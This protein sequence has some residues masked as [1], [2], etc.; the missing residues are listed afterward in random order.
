[1]KDFKIEE[2]KTFVKDIVKN[3]HADGVVIGLSGGKDSAC[4]AA[5]CV[6]AGVKVYGV[7]L[8]IFSSK[9]DDQYVRLL[10]ERFPE[11]EMIEWNTRPGI[12]YSVL[13]E[14]FLLLSDHFVPPKTNMSAAESM[15]RSNIKPRLRMIALYALAQAR[16]CLVVGTGNASEAYVGYFTKWGDGA[17]DFNP[18]ADLLKDEVVELGLLLGV[19]EK[20]MRRQPSAGLW[21]GQTDE[22]EMGFTYADI[23]KVMKDET[24]SISP[25]TA[26]A[27]MTKHF[28]S[29]HKLNPIPTFLDSPTGRGKGI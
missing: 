15:S 13:E 28:R 27:I 4:V 25:E 24:T 17:H 11:I 29:L 18:I 14:A 8:P 2:R 9:E 5:L 16:N 26:R 10:C 21:E 1:M 7:Q 3:A 12:Q 19:P 23:A 6:D 20:C 22:G